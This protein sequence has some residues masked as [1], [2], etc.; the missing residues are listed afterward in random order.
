[1]S[2]KRVDELA[3]PVPDLDKSELCDV[4][5]HRRLHGVDAL[6]LQ[7]TGELRLRREVAVLDQLQDLRLALDLA[8]APVTSRMRSMPCWA[9]SPVIVRGGVMRS[10]VSPAVPTSRPFSSALWATGPAGWCSS[11]ASSS[12]AP[13]TSG[14]VSAKRA[15]TSRTCARRSSSIV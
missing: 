9:S 11:T 8:H 6:L 10:A 2:G 5:G 14:S 12:P 15:P 7:C 1:G 13:R 4:A 3:V